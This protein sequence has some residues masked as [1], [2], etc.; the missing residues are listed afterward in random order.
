M[1]TAS[2]VNEISA[3]GS[4]AQRPEE[5][6]GV[7]PATPSDAHGTD[8]TTFCES[9]HVLVVI[10]PNA[11]IIG[12]APTI[13]DSSTK[14]STVTGRHRGGL[15]GV[16]YGPASWIWNVCGF[17]SVPPPPL[18]PPSSISTMSP[19]AYMLSTGTQDYRVM[20]RRVGCA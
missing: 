10:D 6:S 9:H 8:A 15:V 12:V 18:W 1:C 17:C 20:R 7:R 11:G 5:S 13:L 4:P 19:S 3:T 14:G 2:T 16:G